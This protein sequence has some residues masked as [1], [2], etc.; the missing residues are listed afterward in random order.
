MDGVGAL[1]IRHGC[2]IDAQYRD[3]VLTVSLPKTEDAKTRK[4]P[5]KA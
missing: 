5:V 4:I 3:G 1:G 2:D